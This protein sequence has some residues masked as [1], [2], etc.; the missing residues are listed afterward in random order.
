MKL[1]GEQLISGLAQGPYCSS[2]T[3][4]PERRSQ[5]AVA[6]LDGA[7]IRQLKRARPLLSGL[8]VS[9][10]ALLSHVVIY[11][12]ETGLPLL[13]VEQLPR[14]GEGVQ[15]TFGSAEEQG[16]LPLKSQV[17]SLDGMFVHLTASVW[18]LEG[19][20]AAVESGLEI[21]LLR[22]ETLSS[23]EAESVYRLA[24]QAPFANIRLADYS[25]DKEALRS[26]AESETRRMRRQLRQ[27][28]KLPPERLGILIPNVTAPE[29]VRAVTA[30]VTALSDACILP[31][32][33]V[34]LETREAFEQ[35]RE[36]ITLC[37]FA[38]IGF[39]ALQR[40]GLPQRELAGLLR[41]AAAEAARQGVKLTLCGEPTSELL[42]LVLH[43]GVRRLAL[44]PSQLL[45]Y[46][47]RIGGLAVW[48]AAQ[49]VN[50]GEG[51]R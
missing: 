51:Q 2:L 26:S 48:R 21:G 49:Q 29:Q 47:N 34:M 16:L 8:I 7:E 31:R 1:D 20:A 30:A 32:I 27:L 43:A 35:L 41:A 24:V 6:V 11:A 37:D 50:G 36:L 17:V 46:V 12:K 39:N 33:G 10:A 15:I 9:R 28:L 38:N 5:G 45:D 19:V 3:R 22:T 4:L 13:V 23:R 14:I 18:E 44:P 42:P 40:M 25:G